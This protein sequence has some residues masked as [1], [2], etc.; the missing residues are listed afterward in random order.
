MHDYHLL[1]ILALGFSLA[2]I[3]GY[4][5]HRLGFS[6]IVGYL[7]AG[8]LVGPQSPGFVADPS[9]AT[10]LSEAVLFFSCSA[11]VSTLI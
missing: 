7:I 5:T 11:S 1:E 2:L 4:I 6:P 8:F 3:F 9:L 10:Q